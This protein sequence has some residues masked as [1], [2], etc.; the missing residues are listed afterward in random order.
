[1][2]KYKGVFSARHLP[3]TSPSTAE[4]TFKMPP[5]NAKAAY[6]LQ[7]AD[8]SGFTNPHHL[9][10]VDMFIVLKI[11]QNEILRFT[12]VQLSKERLAASPSL[13]F[14]YVI[15]GFL[16]SQ[17]Y[18]NFLQITDGDKFIQEKIAT[19][20]KRIQ[21]LLPL[22]YEVR[23]LNLQYV[24]RKCNQMTSECAGCEKCGRLRR[25]NNCHKCH[26]C[27]QCKVLTKTKCP[28]TN[29][30]FCSDECHR[31]RRC[32]PLYRELCC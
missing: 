22:L 4:G 6:K 8:V 3:K 14:N 17:H 9:R 11:F 16:T 21:H 27:L 31:T 12:D 30:R 24:C 7:I 10:F 20:H 25:C 15:R 26:I 5:V 32:D 1:M 18:L 29:E 19:F 28:V 2:E 13:T 23:G